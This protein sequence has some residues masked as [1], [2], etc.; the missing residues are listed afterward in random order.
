VRRAGLTRNG[1][2]PHC[3]RG[4]AYPRGSERPGAPPVSRLDQAL[5]CSTQANL[6]IF[7]GGGVCVC[8]LTPFPSISLIDVVLAT[9]QPLVL[10]PS[11]SLRL[12]TEPAEVTG[13]SKP[14]VSCVEP[15]VA[16]A[17]RTGPAPTVSFFLLN[18]EFRNPQSPVGMPRTLRVLAMTDKWEGHLFYL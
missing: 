8:P 17:L 5:I 10:N 16:G 15:E 3:S 13:L 14:V 12:R 18:S 1:P 2:A 7:W 9:P 11:T 6:S 4:S